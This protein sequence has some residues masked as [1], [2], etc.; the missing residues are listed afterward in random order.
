MG[1]DIAIGIA[2]G[3]AYIGVGGGPKNPGC[4]CGRSRKSG[5]RSPRVV[6]A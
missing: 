5:R 1:A 3:A 4:G 2:G 6:A